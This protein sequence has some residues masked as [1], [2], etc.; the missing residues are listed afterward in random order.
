MMT[1]L[2]IESRQKK[3]G[4]HWFHKIAK[5]NFVTCFSNHIK[6]QTYENNTI[7]QS[8]KK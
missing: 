4:D 6:S 7:P 3:M 5:H 2:E 1:K 8:L